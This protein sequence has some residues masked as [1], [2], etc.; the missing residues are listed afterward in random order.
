MTTWSL[1]KQKPSEL[2]PRNVVSKDGRHLSA[3]VRYAPVICKTPINSLSVSLR[4]SGTLGYNLDAMSSKSRSSSPSSSSSSP[5]ASWLFA[6]ASE[7]DPEL[8]RVFRSILFS[9]F[10]SSVRFWSSPSLSGS[11][12]ALQ[13]P[14]LHSEYER[15]GSLKGRES[16]GAPHHTRRQATESRHA[17]SAQCLGIQSQQVILE[18][19][20]GLA[21]ARRMASDCRKVYINNLNHSGA[22]TLCS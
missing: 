21:R 14:T 8:S 13:F 16:L 6:S 2:W 7:P 1:S 3:S 15:H 4:D 18:G 19:A 12:A 17:Y 5:S 9:S 10:P 20:G 11:G 22:R